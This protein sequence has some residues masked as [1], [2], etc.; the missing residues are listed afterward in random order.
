MDDTFASS[1]SN[2]PEPPRRFD[3]IWVQFFKA[4][5]IQGPRL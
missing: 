4:E 1:K 3:L 2:E 5:S